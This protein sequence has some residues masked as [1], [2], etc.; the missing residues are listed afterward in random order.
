MSQEQPTLSAAE[1]L[2]DEVWEQVH[3]DTPPA[4]VE[5]I[6]AQLGQ[7][8]EARERINTEG[9]VVRDM[10]GSVIPHPALKVEA[11]ATKLYATL[12]AKHRDR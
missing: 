11:D 12:L 2:R 8:R 9:S 5:A 7:A 10:R 4:I 1:E 3:C 6:A